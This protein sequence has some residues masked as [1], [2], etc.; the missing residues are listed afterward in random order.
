MKRLNPRIGISKLKFLEPD[1]PRA[2]GFQPRAL[3]G[4]RFTTA[5]VAKRLTCNI[6]FLKLIALVSMTIDHTNTIYFGGKY[7]LLTAIG[8]LAFPLFIFILVFNYHYHTRNPRRY[9]GR[10]FLFALISQYIY[11]IAFNTF[12][13]NILFTLGVGLLL[14]HN[15]RGMRKEKIPFFLL[16]LL[17]IYTQY[18]QP[19]VEIEFGLEGL[20]LI[21]SF[22]LYLIK[23]TNIFLGMVL[24]L[25][26]DLN[27]G[28]LDFNS[29]LFSLSTLLT[30]PVVLL[31][32]RIDWKLSFVFRHR[33]I[34]YLY[35]P[36]HLSV[37]VIV[38]SLK[39]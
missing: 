8:R 6:N 4:R 12:R 32:N 30:I 15:F 1:L 24:V 13:L 10:I 9:L 18:Y 2:R 28:G 33:L 22:S 27:F 21:Y 3:E 36:L 34:F 31:S 14:I 37:L 5:L 26:F 16:F 11:I 19:K 35:Y 7:P 38:R 25:L 29:I 20:L 17:W 23:R 39:F